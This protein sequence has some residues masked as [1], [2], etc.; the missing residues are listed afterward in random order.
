MFVFWEGG[1]EG[2]VASLVLGWGG[3][4]EGRQRVGGAFLSG[5]ILG[6][7]LTGGC[8]CL[9]KGRCGG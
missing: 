8:M 4:G 7:F 5:A 6:T 1:G 9:L 3:C 2:G